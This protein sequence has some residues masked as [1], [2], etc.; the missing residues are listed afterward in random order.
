MNGT[1]NPCDGC[2]PLTGE[3]GG[4]MN[5]Y[6][7]RQGNR[8]EDPASGWVDPGS[9]PAGG[10]TA[11]SGWVWF[12]GIMM[13]M[14]G[15]FGAIEGLV[16][17]FRDQYYVV[18]PYNVL[19]F[20]ITGWG[21]VHLILGVLVLLTGI[22]LL[23]DAGWARVVTVILVGLDALVQLAFIGVYPLWSIIVI[24]MCVIVIWAIVVHG[25]ESR[26]DL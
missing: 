17:L 19:V 21:W 12:A 24:A 20:D 14:M 18:G 25:D 6:S 4:S 26:L 15:A 2:G 13:I 16:A 10:R 7:R 5:G 3:T 1:E 11:W 9:V 22:A 23:A 8:V